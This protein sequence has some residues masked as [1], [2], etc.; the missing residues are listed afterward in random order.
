MLTDSDLL[1][2][3]SLL[4]ES[5]ERPAEDLDRLIEPPADSPA[6][7][8]IEA[9]DT[10]VDEELAVSPADLEPAPDPLAEQTPDTILAAK[11]E[12]VVEPDISK[13]QAGALAERLQDAAAAADTEPTN[14]PDVSKTQAGALAERVK[15]TANVDNVIGGQ[16]LILPELR[17][18]ALSEK[19]IVDESDPGELAASGD[20][21]QLPAAGLNG[22]AKHD[23]A[24]DERPANQP[25]SLTSF[26][27][28]ANSP[29]REMDVFSH[30][31][32]PAEEELIDAEVVNSANGETL[33]AELRPRG[34]ISGVFGEPVEPP[35]HRQR[36]RP[37]LNGSLAAMV[38]PVRGEISEAEARKIRRKY[39]RRVSTLVGL[40]V[41]LIGGSAVTIYNVVGVG[42][43]A[44]AKLKF[45][46]LGSLKQYDR[47]NF[48]T[49][50]L[51]LLR[52]NT[53]RQLARRRLNERD[54]Q[55]PPG[56]LD[57]Q[58]DYVK[59]SDSVGF[60]ADDPEIML[61]RING[62]D[63]TGDA[64]RAFAMGVAL[65]EQDGTLLDDARKQRQ[66]MDD[67]KN[68]IADTQSQLQTITDQINKLR[69]SG[70]SAP[71][72]ERRQQLDAQLAKSE[73]DWNNAVAA[74]KSAE[75]E[76]LRMKA[77]APGSP[78][79][80]PTTAPAV[81]NDAQMLALQQQ[82]A[83]SNAKLKANHDAA[84]K[85]AV[86]ARQNLDQT[87]AG[88]GK[89]VA[90]AQGL[91]GNSPEF[92]AY[93]QSAQRLLQTTKELT[94]GLIRRQEML[95]GK[96]TEFQGQLNDRMDARRVELWQS[97]KELAD[98]N[99]QLAIATRLF[100]TAQGAGLQKESDEL[101]ARIDL[102]KS[103][104]KARQDL[105]PGDAFYSDTIQRLQ[106]I[107]DQQKKNI[108]E[109]R[110][111]TEQQLTQLQQSFTSSA[112]VE[113]LPE[114]Q[115][116]LATSLSQRLNDINAAR[117]QYNQAVD[118]G[119][120]NSDEQIK[121]QTATLQAALEAR[122][123]QLAD[124]N[125]DALRAQQEHDRV[126]AVDAKESDLS[127]LRATEINLQKLYF[128]TQKQVRE[129]QANADSAKDTSDKLDGLIRQKGVLQA[130]LDTKNNQISLRQ[131]Q[132]TAVIEP[133]KPLESDVIIRRGEDRRLFDTLCVGGVLLALF[134]GLILW[135]LH[136][137]HLI[138]PHTALQA[139]DLQ[140][141]A[142][143]AAATEP[144]EPA[145]A[146]PA[147]I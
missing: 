84:A 140:P 85:A 127:K 146:K 78:A 40:M 145:D 110:A 121:S 53:T 11:S 74:V 25:R 56:F 62:K 49:Q 26:E 22:H 100:N 87:L 12:P 90:D 129:A 141:L 10:T 108:A 132:V 99:E 75:A 66:A 57:D 37:E 4:G 1:E 31:S 96:L 81:A 33:P 139:T 128:D 9:P 112:V 6:A 67:L 98:L 113:Q 92:T 38:Q 142:A 138:A 14:E 50:Q 91:A 34:T 97:D 20:V 94:D 133:Q 143:K 59:N 95:L 29:L 86:D 82:L 54:P 77:A 19:P 28:L 61:L 137:A 69:L 16:P 17:P 68:S 131:A 45:A 134:S 60:S 24:A 55:I 119:A 144:V 63:P 107:L 80:A 15:W 52:Q 21:G 43:S 135:T 8:Q 71:S 65:Y 102:N 76:L 5:E 23:I 41:L 83:D 136:T 130:D 109:D 35:A 13:T 93:I 111:A 125:L 124:A 36:V 7:S 39:V 114:E 79:D 32:P 27:G 120:G 106:N 89:Q 47:N 70:E 2:L 72:L 118:A 46:N 48:V 18:S 58:I 3:E 126:A 88:F 115:K 64:A 51:D 73:T 123:K 122:Q 44:E 101:K 42:G 103:L 147:S 116:Q 30:M 104:I 105:L 117:K